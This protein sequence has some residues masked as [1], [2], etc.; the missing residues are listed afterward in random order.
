V[1]DARL[2]PVLAYLANGATQPVEVRW[3]QRYDVLGSGPYRLLQDGDH[4]DTVRTPDDV[5]YVLYGRCH[6]RALE[7]LAATGWAWLHGGIVGVAG[8]R[9]LLVG[10]KGV[11]KTTLALRMLHDGHR[12]EG[13]ELVLIRDGSALPLPRNLH[14]KEGSVALVPELAARWAELPSIGTS[15]GEVIR[16]FSPSDAGFAWDIH[17]GGVDVAVVLRAGHGGAASGRPLTGVELVQRFVE[18]ASVV[19]EARQQLVRT[20]A[21]LV[22]HVAG[23]EL[24]IGDLAG[25]TAALV[26]MS[27]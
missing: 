13:D 1:E 16:A 25:T 18:H 14:V 24:T 15:S 4:L 6:A 2:A 20:L 22:G 7:P 26:A 21:G 3:T 10:D 19:P 11:G 23:H 8:R 5:L 12:V 17:D 9:V 27:A